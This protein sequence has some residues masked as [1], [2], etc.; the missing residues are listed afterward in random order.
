MSK[1]GPL[2]IFL[3]IIAVVLMIPGVI[4]IWLGKNGIVINNAVIHFGATTTDE[5]TYGIIFVSIGIVCVVVFLLL[6]LFKMEA[7]KT[8]FPHYP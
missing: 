1:G 3:I 4:S 6:F 5:I 7:L 8:E 2:G